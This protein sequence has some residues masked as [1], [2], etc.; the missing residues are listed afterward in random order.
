MDSLQLP[1]APG[2]KPA[3][4]PS[5]LS[6]RP[7]LPHQGPPPPGRLPGLPILH[8]LTPRSDSPC[9][10]QVVVSLCSCRT[11]GAAPKLGDSGLMLVPSA[12]GASCLLPLSSVFTG[13]WVPAL[14]THPGPAVDTSRPWAPRPSAQGRPSRACLV[15]RARLPRGSRATGVFSSWEKH[16]RLSRS[17]SCFPG[18]KHSAGSVPQPPA[19]RQPGGC[20]GERCPSPQGWRLGVFPGL[21]ARRHHPLLCREGSSPGAQHIGAPAELLSEW[22]GDAGSP[23]FPAPVPG[24]P[25]WV[26]P[27]AR[28][29]GVL[30][31][32][33]LLPWTS[34]CASRS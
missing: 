20:L 2:F 21:P 24:P 29:N 28:L 19:P 26:P 10:V 31:Q 5:C 1:Q 12:R 13:L 7:A 33:P 9:P 22:E 25:P 4:M 16:S 14:P 32:D 17:G 30:R 8:T 18:E 23:G 3:M 6:A 11:S 15:G 27:S 34:S